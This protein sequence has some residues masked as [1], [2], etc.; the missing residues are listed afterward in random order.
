MPDSGKLTYANEG[1]R[2]LSAEERRRL[3]TRLRQIADRLMIPLEQF[4]E[5]NRAG[6][7]R[8]ASKP[9]RSGPGRRPDDP[10]RGKT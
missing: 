1:R 8:P 10:S 5:L 3:E 2:D 7:P 4:A 6:C 9:A